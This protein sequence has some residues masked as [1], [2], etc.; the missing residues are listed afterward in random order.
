MGSVQRLGAVHKPRGTE[1]MT[2]LQKCFLRMPFMPCSRLLGML[3]S[4]LLKSQADRCWQ[5]GMSAQVGLVA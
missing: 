4:D 1:G 5:V 2:L 3:R